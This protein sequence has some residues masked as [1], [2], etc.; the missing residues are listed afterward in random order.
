MTAVAEPVRVRPVPPVQAALRLGAVSDPLET[1]ADAVAD[2]VLRMPDPAIAGALLQRCPGGCPSEEEL[3]RQPVEDEEEELQRQPAEEEEDLL[4][5]QVD[6]RLVPNVPAETAA[7]IDAARGGGN[8]LPAPVRDFFAPR[9]GA[10]LSPVR[11]HGD[12]HAASL[13]ASVNARAFT[14]GREVFFG[15]GEYRPGTASG[16]RLLAHELAHT[17]QQGAS[18]ATMRRR[19]RPERVTC[20]NAR[21]GSAILNRTGT[22]DPVGELQTADTRG[23]ELLDATIATLTHGRTAVL[24]GAVPA[25]PTIGDVTAVALRD[26]L[27]LDPEDPAVWTGTGARTVNTVIR[28][29]QGA[30]RHLVEG[31]LRYQCIG[32]PSVSSHAG[33][34]GPDCDGNT[35]A[36][37]CPPSN[38]VVL[39]EPFWNSTNDERALT[40]L[41]EAMHIFF[42]AVGD[43]GRFGNAGCYEQLV[44]DLHGLGDQQVCS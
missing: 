26:R 16:D 32:S 44:A 29:F 2:R 20:R 18:R 14:V 22:N 10:D 21:P 23:M 42:D 8:P 30:R 37:T 25:W 19:V 5:A 3:R 38:R 24:R 43:T 13:A 41:H 6:H 31:W 27:G 4:A 1:E 12:G 15:A 40:L 35:W 34:N 33:C 39:C 9:L 11:V 7:G 28:R 17:V 36:S